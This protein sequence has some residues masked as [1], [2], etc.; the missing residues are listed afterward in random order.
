MLFEAQHL[1]SEAAIHVG[2]LAFE[3]LQLS[4]MF[5]PRI[6]RGRRQLGA[7]KTQP[8]RSEDPFREE[9]EDRVEHFVLFDPEY[10]G[11]PGDV[12]SDG[13][14][15]GDVLAAVP[16]GALLMAA[17]HAAPAHAAADVTAQDVEPASA[18]RSSAVGA[19]LVRRSRSDGVAAGAF[20]DG[21]E[22]LSGDERL[23]RRQRAP[24]PL[25][26][27]ADERSAFA[28]VVAVPDVVAGVLRV[29]QH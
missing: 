13:A 19:G 3:P 21:L 23:V 25:L 11:V 5:S 22:Q 6:A 9:V 26:A 8:A 17:F 1:A 10:A 7:E 2:A 12:G 18:P 28:L 4:V 15:A 27:C 24:D 14:S 29:T 16:V 20:L